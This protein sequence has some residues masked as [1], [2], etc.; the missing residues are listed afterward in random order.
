MKNKV[1]HLGLYV[2]LSSVIAF[3]GAAKQATK[4]SVG[5]VQ[6]SLSD[7]NLIKQDGQVDDSLL[8]LLKLVG[9]KHEGTIESINT[10]MQANFLRKPGEERWHLSDSDQDEKS[11][12]SALALLK[13]MSMV[14]EI[15]HT[16]A[17]ADYFLVFG[18]ILPRIEQRFK[19][20]VVQ[21]SQGT[22][23]CQNIVLLGGVRKLQA[24]ELISIKKRLGTSLSH[25]LTRLHKEE[26]E[27][28]EAD[29]LR[30][31]WDTQATP[32]LKL[33]FKEGK[34]L[35]LINSTATTQGTNNRPT[36]G[37]TIETWLRDFRPRPGSCH[38]NVEKPYGIRMEK[39]LRLC[40]EKYSRQLAD[41]NTNFSITWNSPAADGN[42]SLAV[43]KD[44]LA[45]TF[46]QEYALK[47]FLGV[48]LD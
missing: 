48:G 27:L 24:N 47:R 46:Y 29:V 45:R 15:S 14:D 11:R 25:F 39:A 21:Y 17:N 38:A 33:H 44:E 16:K 35:F 28:T 30:F 18:G 23:H 4:S 42:L 13:K 3:A 31:I 32:A 19:D 5:L 20:F 37:S 26:E 1:K 41:D 34:N 8:K 10:A 43:Y 40:L 6:S 9:I 2:A 7:I 12:A 36:T 22:L